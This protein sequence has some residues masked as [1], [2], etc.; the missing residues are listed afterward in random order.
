MG[1]IYE[2]AVKMGSDAV[3]YIPS[4]IKVGS[5]IQKLIGGYYYYYYYYHHHHVFLMG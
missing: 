1:G 2:C 4:F 3:K 5:A